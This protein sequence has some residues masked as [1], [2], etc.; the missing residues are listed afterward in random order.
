MS[1]AVILSLAAAL[2]ATSAGSLTVTHRHLVAVCVDGAPVR[3]GTRS[4]GTGDTPMTLTFTMRNQPRTGTADAPAGYATLTFKP[5]AGHRYEVEVRSPPQTFSQRVWPEGVWTPVVRDRT[6][7][8]VVSG[9]VGWGAAA[10]A[11]APASAE[12]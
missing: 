6:T 7:D 2:A 9:D 8:S 3:A 4:W 10:C 12:H 1:T 5:T 11:T